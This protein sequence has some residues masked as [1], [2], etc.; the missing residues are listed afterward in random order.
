MANQA[1]LAAIVSRMTDPGAK[2]P[3]VFGLALSAGLALILAP[4]LRAVRP[5]RQMLVLVIV[6]GLLM[7]AV[8][9]GTPAAIE[10]DYHRYMWDG[11]V[12]AHA[13]DPYRYAPQHF[14][15]AVAMPME[16]E[17]LARAG[18]SA[19]EHVNFPDLNSLYPSVAQLSFALAYFIAPF[20]LDAL[21]AVFLAAEIAT[22]LLLIVLLADSKASSLWSALYW[23]NPLPIFTL[24]GM[25]HVDA[26]VP[27]FVLGAM[28]LAK[29][30]RPNAAVAMLAAG[31]GVKI[32]PLLLAPLLLLPLI[33]QPR[34]FAC[35]ALVFVAAVGLAIGPLLLSVFRP[36]SG[37][38]AYSS[39]WDV[40][41][42][43]FAWGIYGLELALGDDEPAQ[44]VLRGLL[45]FATAG[46]ALL[47]ARRH[48]QGRLRPCARGGHRVGDRI[49]SLA[50][51]VSLVC[52]MVP[53]AGGTPAQ[54]A[55]A[56]RVGDLAVVLFGGSAV[57]GRMGSRLLLWHRLSSLG[58]GPPLADDRR[59][60]AT[61]GVA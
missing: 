58:A 56:S 5:T 31:A 34:R 28:L 54:L 49:L 32:W 4:N 37:L 38:V 9:F 1:A 60:S 35:A 26:L 51:P 43:F 8:W 40:N 30:G 48:Q 2:A 6:A 22:F 52:R 23:W 50:R 18:R 14:L 21:R 12:V 13:L 16:F 11:A 24:I 46:T 33:R 36:G 45:A 61:P 27:P 44:K 55:A 53:A 19:L 57:A 25:A 10:D 42:A 7:R 47:V 41:N 15:S 39:S 17:A 20:D 59:I 3:L 29:R